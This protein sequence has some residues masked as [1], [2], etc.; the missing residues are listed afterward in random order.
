MAQACRIAARLRIGTEA[1]LVTGAWTGVNL[2]S[3]LARPDRGRRTGARVMRV[4]SLGFVLGTLFLLDTSLSV[5]LVKYAVGGVPLR[6]IVSIVLLAITGL[7][8]PSLLATGIR[9]LQLPIMII[10]YCGLVAILSSVLNS[11][12]L[13]DLLQQLLELHVQAV[14]SLLVGYVVLAVCGPRWTVVLFGLPIVLSG[15]VAALQFLGVGIAWSAHDFLLQ[16]QPRDPTIL[17]TFRDEQGRAMGLSFDPVH[18]G[19]EACLLFAACIGYLRRKSVR[20]PVLHGVDLRVLLLFVFVMAIAVV[21][22]NRSPLLGFVVS[23][24]LYTFFANRRL[25]LFVLAAA[26]AAALL[27]TAI[28]A[29]LADTGLR[30]LDTSNSSSENR[31]VL[32]KLGMLLFLHR[33]F[34]YG[35]NFDSTQ[36]WWFF[37]DQLAQYPNSMAVRIDALHNYYLMILN[38]NGFLLLAAVPFV[39]RA[40]FSSRA[41]LLSFVPYMIHIFFHNTGPLQG[42]VFIWFIMPMFMDVARDFRRAGIT[43]A[44]TSRGRFLRID[45][46]PLAV[47]RGHALRRQT[48]N[49]IEDGRSPAAT[50]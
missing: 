26:A 22:G 13:R 36:H 49:Q 45:K 43:T 39:I 11:T 37:W 24:L 42:D 47:G 32:R 4:G 27:W 8:C 34:G 15:F 35:V 19:T 17:R 40:L 21:S 28:D 29:W 10:G 16:L 3:S 23:L 20:F 46:R 7:M 44:R 30:A 14:V 1:Y 38:K 9:R 31:A 5:F 12:P 2:H 6:A 48:F 50:S 25:F 18:L 33:P 41:I